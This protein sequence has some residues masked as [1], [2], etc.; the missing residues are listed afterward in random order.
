MVALAL[1]AA[2]Q[3][4]SAPL[5]TTYERAESLLVV[6]RLAEARRLAE[7]LQDRRPHDPRVLMLLGR[8]HLA[9]PVVGR[10]QADT[11]FTRAARLD[12][13][14]PE[15]PWYVGQVGLRLGGT[16]GEEIARRGFL[17]VLAVDPDYRDAWTQWSALYRGPG[18]RQDAVMAL[19]RNAGRLWDADYWRSQ[20]LLE[21]QRYAEAGALLEDVVRR[22]PEDPGPRA[23]LARAQF[24]AGHDADGAASYRAALDRE[25]HD[26]GEVLWKQVRGAASPAE[27]QAYHDTPPENRAAFLRLWWS[28]RDPDL[29]SDVN[30]RMAEHFRR[31]AEAQQYF[32]LRFPNSRYFQSALFRARAGGVG[33]YP[34]VA[35]A[36]LEGAEQ[37]AA[38]T[39]CSARRPGVSDAAARAGLVPRPEDSNEPPE[40]LEDGLD[41]RGRI[42]LRHGRPDYRFVGRLADETWCYYREDGRMFR[43]TFVRRTGG[44]GATGD[45]VLTPLM[46]GESEAAAELLVTDNTA[47][48][49]TLNFAF[50]NASFRAADRNLTELLVIPD[51][52][53]AVAVLLDDAGREV[54]RDTATGRTLRLTAPPGA[55]ALLMD[56]VRGRDTSRYRG[57]ITLPDFGGEAPA[58]SSIL[59]ATG[60]VEPARDALAAHA[61]RELTMRATRTLRVYAELYNLGRADGIARYRAEYWFERTD[62]GFIGRADR[63]RGTTIAF[64]RERP[65][66]PRLVETLVVDPDR[67]PPGRYRLHIEVMD[68][69]RSSRAVSATIEFRLR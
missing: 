21:L 24:L 58:I 44:A 15:P 53:G 63:E 67:L 48:R 56:A 40:N 25:G 1:I 31:L 37:R 68:Q 46:A 13:A 3:G 38:D 41:D 16:D 69:V 60:D 17:G 34:G 35:G 10:H 57:T 36:G 2:L 27:R 47:R 54:A 19:E 23:W 65:F 20:L 22:R 61:P 33:G 62:G 30:E 45:M 32:A 4:F 51:S 9:W 64:D 43:V 8:I 26:S 12:P 55:Y 14:N 5:D 29:S 11:L 18:A 6:G 28:R 66:A 52:I 50:W 49:N 7:R 42:W 59:I 39:Q